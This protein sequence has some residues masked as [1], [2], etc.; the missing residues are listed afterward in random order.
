MYQPVHFG[1]GVEKF[2]G[3]L[4]LLDGIFFPL[5]ALVKGAANARPVN[6]PKKRPE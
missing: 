6:S 4:S 5:V 1:T 2:G 3:E